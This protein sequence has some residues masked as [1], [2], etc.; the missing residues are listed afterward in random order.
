[1]EKNNLVVGIDIGGSH[2]TAGLVEMNEVKVV[3]SSVLRKKLNSHGTADEIITVWINSIRDVIQKSPVKISKL[4]FAMPGPFDYEKGIC[5]IKDLHKYEA[6]YGMNIKE[7]LV[8][9]LQISPENILFRNDAE[10]FLAGELYGGAAKGFQ[11][12]IGITLGTGLG[13]AISHDGVTVDAEL[14]VM[15]YKGEIIEEFVST[16]GL[17]RIYE[18]L[19][20]KIRKDVKE[21]SDLYETDLN[22]KKAFEI[23]GN[24]LSFFL[25]EFI[26]REKPEVLVIGGNIANSWNL[27]MNDVITTLEKTVSKMPVIVRAV[28]AEDAA[29]IG[30]ACSFLSAQKNK[31]SVVKL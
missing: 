3:K 2:I 22:A 17:L 26:N 7:I 1:M 25:Q 20:G 24:H 29:L 8:E 30:G 12:A 18:L 28:L 27:F 19:T 11:H 13:S 21:I 6:L 15:P 16:R 23:L 5:L 14:G 9:A 31:M 10:A 4:G